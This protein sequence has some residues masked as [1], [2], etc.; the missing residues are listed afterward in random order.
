MKAVTKESFEQVFLDKARDIISGKKESKVCTVLIPKID[1][2]VL[3][4]ISK[5]GLFDDFVKSHIATSRISQNENGVIVTEIGNVL[6]YYPKT[7]SISIEDANIDIGKESELE[8]SNGRIFVSHID[9]FI[10]NY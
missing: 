6:S 4:E 5:D 9:S 7:K 10:P 1:N 2:N 8:N 3:D